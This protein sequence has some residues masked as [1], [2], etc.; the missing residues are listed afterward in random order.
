MIFFCFLFSE[1]FKF[2]RFWEFFIEFSKFYFY[3]W[4]I[5][6]FCQ[7]NRTKYIEWEHLVYIISNIGN[8]IANQFFF[9]IVCYDGNSRLV[10]LFITVNSN[11]H[12]SGIFSSWMWNERN[13]AAYEMRHLAIDKQ[14]IGIG[15]FLSF[16]FGCM[17][18]YFGYG[19]QFAVYS[20]R[21]YHLHSI[22]QQCYQH[23]PQTE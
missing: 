21:S 6:V 12:I 13:N 5:F 15:I 20:I 22:C 8:E 11:I 9:A 4:H 14:Y 2:G 18:A 1:K 7:W 17:G 10:L 19:F 3:F 16:F 23:H